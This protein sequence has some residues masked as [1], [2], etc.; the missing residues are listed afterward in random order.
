MFFGTLVLNWSLS[1]AVKQRVKDAVSFIGAYEAA[2]VRYVERFNVQGV[3]C[4]HIHNAPFVRNGSWIDRIGRTW[5]LNPGKQIGPYPTCLSF[6]LERMS[7][8]WVSL[9]GQGKQQ[10]NIPPGNFTD[11]A[12]AAGGE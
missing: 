2:I 11:P 1:K 9:E 7:V 12:V 6:D 5:V 4:G 3:L 10:L 8:E